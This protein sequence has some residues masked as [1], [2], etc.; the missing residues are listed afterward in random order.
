MADDRA[1]K[2]DY[3]EVFTYF[4]FKDLNGDM[5]EIRPWSLK[6]SKTLSKLVSEI[7][8]QAKMNVGDDVD[9]VEYIYNHF[10][11]FLENNFEQLCDILMIT[12][13]KNEAW[14]EHVDHAIAISAL[15]VIYQQNFCG[16]RVMDQMGRFLVRRQEPVA[17]SKESL[18][19][20]M[21]S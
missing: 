6:K 14:L 20:P 5:I 12:C 15:F 17:K 18:L 3:D 9:F 10:D 11:I 1:V 16:P 4:Q 21:I 8:K 13:D 2:T 19:P 7:F